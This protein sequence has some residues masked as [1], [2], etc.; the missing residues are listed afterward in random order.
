MNTSKFEL[1]KMKI[2]AVGKDNKHRQKLLPS[3]SEIK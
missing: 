2:R 1:A 3:G